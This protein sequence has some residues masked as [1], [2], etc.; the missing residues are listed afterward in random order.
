MKTAHEVF[1][2]QLEKDK[3]QAYDTGYVSRNFE[4]VLFLTDFR[5]IAQCNSET[6]QRSP[7]HINIIR[8][9]IR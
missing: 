1:Q 7:N 5:S 3:T 6:R 4:T 2:Y 9:Y 8:Y